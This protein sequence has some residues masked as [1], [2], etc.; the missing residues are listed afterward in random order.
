MSYDAR[1]WVCGTT[2]A[3]RA[4]PAWFL[5][6]IADRCRDEHC[7]ACASVPTLMKRANASRTAV[8]DT[9]SPN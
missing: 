9:R 3:A 7:V 1:E 4:P 8:R 5:A 2:A 6:P